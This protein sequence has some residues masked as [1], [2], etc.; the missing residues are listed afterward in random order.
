[1][2]RLGELER[3][4]MNVLWEAAEPVTARQIAAALPERDLAQTTVLTVLSR[5]EAK[6]MVTRR[7]DGRAHTYVAVASREDH[8]A[9]LMHEV[10]GTAGDDADNRAAA[11]ARF[12]DQVSAEDAAALQAALVDAQRLR[13]QGAERRDRRHSDRRHIGGGP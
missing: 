6:R 1:M 11:L 13:R 4:V 12:A 2:A 9:G 3:A 7:R 8:V 5:L 10:L